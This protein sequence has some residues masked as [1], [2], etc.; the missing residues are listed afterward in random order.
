[1]SA[2][3][4]PVRT[5]GRPGHDRE[6]VLRHAVDLF[7]LQGYDATSVSDLAAA[8][9]VT[10]SAVY[11]HFPSKEALLG[12]ALDEALDGLTTAVESAAETAAGGRAYERLR[13]TVTAAVEILADHLPAVTLLLRVRGNSPMEE[14]ALQRRRRIDE[15]FA[16]LARQAAA[17]G[18]LRTDLEPELISRLIFGT[19][20]SLTDWYQ[21]H[22]SLPPAALARALTGVLFDGL[23]PRPPL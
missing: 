1:M 19:V 4:E 20:N 6:S 17:E 11:H 22:G 21:P 18:D 13:A 3:P 16:T 9:G 12:A 15:R 23:H 14:Q 5:R 7:N 2:V 10:K 8:L